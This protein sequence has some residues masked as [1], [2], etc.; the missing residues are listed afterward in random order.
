LALAAR[1]RLAASARAAGLARLVWGRD[2]VVQFRPM[3]ATFA[4]VAVDL[5]P[6]A[7]LQP[8]AEGESFIAAR[9]VEALSG[10][11]RVADLFAGCGALAL[12]LAVAG[13]QVAAYEL[14]AAQVAALGH[15]ARRGAGRLAIEAVARDLDRRPLSASDLAGFGGVVLDP[16]RVGAAPQ[17]R[18]LAS[19]D[20]PVVVYASCNPMTF[21]RDAAVLVGGGYRLGPVAPVDQFVWSPHVELIAAFTR[22]RR[23]GRR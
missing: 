20:V 21:A 9:V 2:T 5:P 18:Q 11:S 22:E 16:P 6:S 12:P 3:S 19:S 17:A 7:F 1:E 23:R 13:K 10:A 15:A 14:E 4:G 8:T